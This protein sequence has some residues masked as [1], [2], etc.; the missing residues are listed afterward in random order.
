MYIH[1]YICTYS[2]M[3]V[4]MSYLRAVGR[5]R[6]GS[7]DLGSVARGNRP[8]DLAGSLRTRRQLWAVDGGQLT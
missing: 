1:I 3:Y 5:A 4:F 6:A 7:K 2:F 8:G